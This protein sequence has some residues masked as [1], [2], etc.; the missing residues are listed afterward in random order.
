MYR[1]FQQD[2]YRLRLET[3]R[4]YAGVLKNSLN[5]ISTSQ[6]EPINLHAEVTGIGPAFKLLIKLQN[7][8]VNQP[9][10]DLYITF[11]FDNKLYSVQKSLIQLPTLV[12]GLEYIFENMLQ[13]ISTVAISDII[14][15]FLLKKT[16]SAPIITAVINMP[17]SEPAAV[18]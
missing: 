3:A 2:L 11:D 9:S 1:Q 17:V 6:A 4:K 14:K 7:T 16:S 10:S 5:P 8:S 12:P 13:C 15:V 18:F